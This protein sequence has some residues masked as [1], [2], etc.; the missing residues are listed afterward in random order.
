MVLRSASVLLLLG[1]CSAQ[2]ATWVVDAANGSG[3][4]FTDLQSALASA[5]V[6]DG[7]TLVV[8]AGVYG[9]CATSKGVTIL[10]EPGAKLASS[11]RTTLLAVSNLAA[12]KT[13]VLD[14]MT[15]E[16]DRFY[17]MGIY[18]LNNLGSVHFDDVTVQGLFVSI[19]SFTQGQS[20]LLVNGCSL[21]TVNASVLSNGAGVSSYNSNLVV[22]ASHVQGMNGIELGFRPVQSTPAFR[23]GNG[24]NLWLAQVTAIGGAGRPT[25]IQ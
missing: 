3:T 16:H 24:G 8:R 11:L 25:V 5:Q 20:S 7:D 13:F 1:I 2:S 21:V 14:R 22:T 15:I 19:P 23:T 17:S 4:H 10:G 12:G 18:L 9:P 6:V